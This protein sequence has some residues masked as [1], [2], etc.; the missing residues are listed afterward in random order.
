M[1]HAQPANAT[2]IGHGPRYVHCPWILLRVSKLQFLPH[3]TRDSTVGIATG[4]GLDGREVWVR[5]P[6][7]PRFSPL[8]VVWSPPNGYHGFL[9]TLVKRPAREADHSPPTGREYVGFYIHSLI[10]FH[11]VV[12]NLLKHRDVTLF[13]TLPH[14][15]I[16]SLLHGPVC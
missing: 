8:H 13:F 12:L 10:R 5:V 9:F 6:V 7:R 16:A 14:K 15:N 3:K 4:Y 1:R 2:A 11:G